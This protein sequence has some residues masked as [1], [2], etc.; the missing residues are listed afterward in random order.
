MN[1]DKKII[2]ELKRF[3]Q[4]NTYILKEQGDAPL[5]EEEPTPEA[6]ATAT[7]PAAPDAAA[8][9][10]AA[11]GTDAAAPEEVAEVLFAHVRLDQSVRVRILLIEQMIA[12]WQLW[13]QCAGI[14]VL[15]S[16]SI[17]E[18]QTALLRLHERAGFTV[19]G[20][21]AFKRIIK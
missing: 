13:C 21:M 8:A 17:R 4:I 7:T 15:V 10:E 12:Q 14:P 6:D 16:S 2:E 20:S 11:T 1:I 3:N 5:P 19:R 9:P 18:D